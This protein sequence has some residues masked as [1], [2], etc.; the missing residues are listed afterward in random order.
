MR[1][2]WTAWNVLL[3]PYVLIPCMLACMLVPAARVGATPLAPTDSDAPSRRWLGAEWYANRLQDW[4]RVDGRIVCDDSRL[5]VRTAHQLCTRIRANPSVH[6]KAGLLRITTVVQPLGG[7]ITRG[8]FAGIL[9]GAGDESV[10]P[11]LSALV[12]QVPAPDGGI[13]AVVDGQGWPMF[14]DFS[15]ERAD[16]FSWSLPTDTSVDTLRVIGAMTNRSHGKFDPT[17]AVTLDLYIQRTRGAVVNAPASTPGYNLTLEV[18]QGAEFIRQA[19]ALDVAAASI[20]GALALVSHRSARKQGIGWSFGGIRY[21]V[22]GAPREAWLAEH[23]ARAWGPVLAC[24][25]TLDRGDDDSHALTLVAHLPPETPFERLGL[26]VAS[27]GGQWRSAGEADYDAASSTVR[28]RLPQVDDVLGGR[29]RVGGVLQGAAFSYEGVIRAPRS[30]LVVASMSCVKHVVALKAWNRSGVW[31]PHEDLVAHVAQHDPDLL[32]FAGDQIYEGD[33]TGVD[34]SNVLLDYHGKFGRWLWSFG[35]LTR[36]RPTVVIP[37][38]HDVFHG[39]LWGSGGVSAVPRDGLSAQDAGGFKLPASTVNAIYRSQTGNLPPRAPEVDAPVGQGIE[40]YSCRLR[41]GPGDFLVLS[42]RLWKDSASALVPEG[43][44][45]NGYFTAE[46]FDPVSS[47]RAAARL[48]GEPQERLLARWS[49]ERDAHSPRKF[50]LSQSPFVAAHTLPK[51]KDDSVVPTLQILREGEAPPDDEPAADTD[52][53]GWPQSARGRAVA[54]F[55]RARALHL[56]GD[57][58]FASVIQY[59]LQ[60]WRDGSF[61]FTAPPIGNTWPRRWM[62]RA[63]GEGGGLPFTGDF[64]DAFGNRFTMCAVA[65]PRV[66]GVEPARLHDLAPGYGIVRVAA[67]GTLV[68][69][70]WPRAEDP[71]VGRPWTGWP[72]VVR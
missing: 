1:R 61:V 22:E 59:G 58:H 57:Q 10:D 64:T 45:V 4:R 32:F 52:T 51:G 31:F 39:N 28:F 40:P 25:Y 54:S 41:F 60:G 21:A 12:Q 19:K 70:A 72:F 27:A 24:T 6:E 48:L 66:S 13:L 46:N 34:A 68:L 53:H 8:C 35:S 9:F 30:E 69:E 29:Y 67:D 20:D 3:L 26:E 5:P 71:A 18:S 2:E 37:D 33:L 65:N 15:T 56:A 62:P 11:R 14:L 44:C 43:T 23:P 50:V 38:D 47:D 63:K 49:E 55:A 7:T 17:R 36:D 42:D 16:K